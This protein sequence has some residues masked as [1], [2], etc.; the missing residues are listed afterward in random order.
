MHQYLRQSARRRVAAWLAAILAALAI[1]APVRAD[2]PI[3][4]GAAIGVTPE[5]RAPLEAFAREV[6]LQQIDAFVG[7]VT[8]I[9]RTGQLPACYLTRR[10]AERLGWRPGQDLWR[11]APGTAIGGDRFRNRE[12]RLPADARYIEA[13]LDYAGGARGA[14]RLV[15][16]EAPRGQR[17]LWVT[18]DHYAS[19]HPVPEP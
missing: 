17:R 2:G 10:N 3:A 13:D 4:C 14:H 9:R 18:V 16:T 5:R 7:T 12:G 1:A 8:A 6:G 19:F 15:F 11:T